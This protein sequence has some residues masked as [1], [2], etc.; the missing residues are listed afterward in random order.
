ML[1]LGREDLH[2]R[3]LRY[4]QSLT[5]AA[6]DPAEAW[7]AA[8][9]DLPSG[10]LQRV[11]D[12]F[13]AAQKVAVSVR[14]YTPRPPVKSTARSMSAAEVH[15]LRARLRDWD[16]PAGRQAAEAEIAY[17][18]AI[19]PDQP[20]PWLARATLR[21]VDG[22]LERSRAGLRRAVELAPSDPRYI[23]PL[24]AVLSMA[25]VDLPEGARVWDE[26]APLVQRLE[27]GAETTMQLNFLAGYY[28]LRRRFGRALHH[29]RRAIASQA[30][31]EVCYDTLAEL[32]AA[33]GQLPS[34]VQAQKIALNLT[35][36]HD[37]T[38]KRERLR[39]LGVY[40]QALVEAEIGRRKPG[41]PAPSAPD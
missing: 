29:A 32:F 2:A 12:D 8:F 19:E 26:I 5:E 4:L 25:E 22:E 14:P 17:A 31:C 6:R 39:R 34:A 33:E 11:F 23:F 7:A 24:A 27:R 35:P 15:V 20:E 18:V 10:E 1:Q 41:H 30:S 28:A 38:A 36:E 37:R 13:V 9:G 40:Q 21:I 16:D 3:F